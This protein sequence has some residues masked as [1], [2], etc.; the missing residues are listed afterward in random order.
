MEKYDVII[1]GAGP[2]GLTAGIYAGRREL[3]TLILGEI[4]GGQ[5][6]YAHLVENYPGVEPMS[7]KELAER[8]KKQAEKFG[9][10]V[11]ME[12][13]VNMELQGEIKKVITREGEYRA[14]VV[15]IATG[16]KPR[17]LKIEG[18]S[19]FLGKGVSYCTI[20]DGPLFKG[21][22][23]IVIGG[24]DAAV[25]SALY[26]S[27]IASQ[28]FLVHRR[29]QLRAEEAN[30]EK[31]KKSP[32]K[33]IWN[34]VVEKI[35]GDEVVRKVLIK[36]LKTN[37]AKELEVDGVFIEIGEVPTT[38]IVKKA[39]VEV[40]EKGYIKVNE[41]METNIKG[42]YAAGDV[43]G[44]LAQIVVAASEGAQAATNAYLYL[45]GGVY[46]ERRKFDWGEKK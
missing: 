3:K 9:C 36:N 24:S 14:D 34:S 40:N 5:M 41:R 7:G 8:M 2:A 21:K 32:V 43:I 4:L 16:S 31:L 13:V 22:K 35:E 17:R 27:E 45:K 12:T 10:E 19:K 20:C 18:E 44:S 28:V 39:G 11:K 42:V 29:D 1:V 26:L 25:T 30:Q 38:E 33:I 6:S 15:I 46:G 37:E 23:V